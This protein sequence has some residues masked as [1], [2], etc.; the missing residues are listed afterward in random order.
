MIEPMFRLFQGQ[1]ARW[2]FIPLHPLSVSLSFVFSLAS[3]SLRW[4]FSAALLQHV[5]TPCSLGF[6]SILTES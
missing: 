5:H 1:S 4:P 2:P 6:V 3:Y